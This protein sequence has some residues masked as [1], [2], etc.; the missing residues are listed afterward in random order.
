MT[1]SHE[2]EQE[3]AG[4]EEEEE[5]TITA[6]GAKEEGQRVPRFLFPA[7]RATHT[8]QENQG[9][10]RRIKEKKNL[11]SRYWCS[12]K[13]GDGSVCRSPCFETGFAGWRPGDNH[14]ATRRGSR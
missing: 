6:R 13:D 10:S 4:E 7:T 1:T 3:R 5:E 8:N 2:Q 12:Q 11:V 9:E 14:G